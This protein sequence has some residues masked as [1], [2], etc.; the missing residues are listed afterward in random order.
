MQESTE[1]S[2]S[3]QAPALQ[4]PASAACR[5]LAGQSHSPYS[6]Q[7]DPLGSGHQLFLKEVALAGNIHGSLKELSV[8][9]VCTLDG[10]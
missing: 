5:L 1:L 7:L 9:W 2:C 3:A 8:G 4:T 6:W 10:L